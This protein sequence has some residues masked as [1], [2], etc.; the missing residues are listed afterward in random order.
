MT[1][2]G[3]GFTIDANNKSRIFIINKNRNVILKDIIFTN[4]KFTNGNGGGVYFNSGG[5]VLNCSFVGC[6]A[7]SSGGAV[8]FNSGGSVVDCSFV[9]CSASS[10]GGAVFFSNGGSVLNC[11]FVGCSAAK[12]NGGAVY[13]N[14]GG[15]CHSG[16]WRLYL[17]IHEL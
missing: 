2:H 4:A 3:N 11:S 10:S 6:S 16:Y 1:I 13:F 5:S 7:S 14:S 15:S 17:C 8:Y 12:S 9:G